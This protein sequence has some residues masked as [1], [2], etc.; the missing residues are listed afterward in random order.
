VCDEYDYQNRGAFGTV[1]L[2][3]LSRTSGSHRIEGVSG[4]AFGSG[5]APSLVNRAGQP[6]G[7][8]SLNLGERGVDINRRGLR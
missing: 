1:A 3:D 5:L 7:S 8:F 4:R 2:Q 6:A